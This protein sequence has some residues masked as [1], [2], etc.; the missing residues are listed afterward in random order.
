MVF[1]CLRPT[2]IFFFLLTLLGAVLSGLSMLLQSARFHSFLR[3]SNVL[4]IACVCVCAYI[5]ICMCLCA[6]ISIRV[7][8]SVCVYVCIRKHTCLY[9]CTYKCT[10]VCAYVSIHVCVHTHIYTHL[11]HVSR[12]LRWT[13]RL[14]PYLAYC[15]RCRSKHRGARVFSRECLFILFCF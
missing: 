14:P 3:L 7:C 12:V 6:Y 8:M 2:E 13:L 5:S 11:H 9:K 1:A 15:W 10:C 4:F